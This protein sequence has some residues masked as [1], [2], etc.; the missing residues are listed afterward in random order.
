MPLKLDPE[1]ERLLARSAMILEEPYELLASRKR[2]YEL[3]A[4]PNPK[5]PLV[6]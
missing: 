1:E 6:R 4:L 3:G 2:L 5:F